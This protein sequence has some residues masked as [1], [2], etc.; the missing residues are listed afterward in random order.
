MYV[1]CQTGRCQQTYPLENFSKDS[2]NVSCEK[3][4][5]ILIDEEGRANFSRNATV[6]PVISMDELTVQREQELKR[7][8]EELELLK[9]EIRVIEIE[10]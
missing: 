1:V 3:C 7:K 9:E 6:I 5:G 8:R 10:L 2:K 4:G